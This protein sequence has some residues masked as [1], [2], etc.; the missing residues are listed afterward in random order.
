[1]LG[2]LFS[3]SPK[4]QVN[5]TSPLPTASAENS[6]G[7]PTGLGALRRASTVTA[8]AWT[9][10]EKQ[11]P[12]GHLVLHLNRELVSHGAEISVL[13]DLYAARG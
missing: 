13:R 6:M 3:P 11:A 10:I 5:V 9:E 4:S 2:S 7:T 1:M 12:F 8:A